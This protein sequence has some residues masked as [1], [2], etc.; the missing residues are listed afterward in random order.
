[1]NLFQ[2]Y[3]LTLELPCEILLYIY[4]YIFEPAAAE[5]THEQVKGCAPF[6]VRAVDK[7]LI[8]HLAQYPR[9]GLVIHRVKGMLSVRWGAI[10]H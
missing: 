1:M 7:V 4:I 8:L 5:T 2:K 9:S 6:V 3:L 10:R